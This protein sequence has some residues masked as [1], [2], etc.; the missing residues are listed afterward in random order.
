ME[1]LPEVTG[2]VARVCPANR[3]D[4]WRQIAAYLRRSPRWCRQ[5]AARQD[6]QRLPTWRLGGRV[7]ATVSELDAWLVARAEETR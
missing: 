1:R 2:R 7:Q 5:W 6:A 4:G 3:L